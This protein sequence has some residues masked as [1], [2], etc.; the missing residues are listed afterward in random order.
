MT[1]KGI[2]NV[3]TPRKSHIK[4]ICEWNDYHGIPYFHTDDFRYHKV[5]KEVG[6]TILRE[7]NQE[8][9]RQHH[10][11]EVSEERRG[12]KPLLSPA[13]LHQAN[14]FLQDVGWD[15]RVL[16][17]AQ[18]SRELDFGVSGRTLQRALGSL[19]YHKCIACTKGWV[20]QRCSHSRVEFSE[21]TL[22]LRPQP[23]D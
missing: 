7:D 1:K 18:L 23:N 14:R 20:S 8:F 19:D 6:W 15:A 12:R 4:G 13:Q 21:A 22:Q 16:T 10:N 5:S 3:D 17:W 2:L 9:D 11:N